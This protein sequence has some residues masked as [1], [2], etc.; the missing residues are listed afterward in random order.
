MYIFL[1]YVKTALCFLFRKENVT[2]LPLPGQ[3]PLLGYLVVNADLDVQGT[4][5]KHAAEKEPS[6][7]SIMATLIKVNSPIY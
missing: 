4:I 1:D 5:L 2:A 3:I 7:Y 6:P